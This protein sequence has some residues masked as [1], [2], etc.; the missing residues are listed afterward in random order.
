[1]RAKA[2]RNTER[3]GGI[4]PG[5]RV[6][7]TAYRQR[8]ELT[9]VTR[10]ESMLAAD[11]LRQRMMKRIYLQLLSIILVSSWY[12][13]TTAAITGQSWEEERGRREGGR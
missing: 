1:M 10:G 12:L 5:K 7:Y 6:G 3:E 2:N 8:Q 9:R 4:K 11:L 13:A